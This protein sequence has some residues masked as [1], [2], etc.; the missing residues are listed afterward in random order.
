MHVMEREG[1]TSFA[2]S[3]V[4]FPRRTSRMTRTEVASWRWAVE[5][6]VLLVGS[7]GL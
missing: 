6:R 2:F 7:E 3:V 4:S 1:N 5:D